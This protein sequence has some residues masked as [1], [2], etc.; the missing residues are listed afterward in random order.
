MMP[1]A[2]R[3]KA[4]T[5]GGA[6]DAW[7]PGLES[8]IPARL[9]PR[10][11]LF[12]PDNAFSG[13]AEA[14]EASE[15]CG[16]PAARMADLKV[17]RMAVHELLVR[18][19]ADLTVPDG[20]DYE[21]LG[22]SLR[23]MVRTIHEKHVVPA[24]PALEGEYAAIRE[25]ALARMKEVLGAGMSAPEGAG[26][27]LLSRLLGRGGPGGRPAQDV[28]EGPREEQDLALVRH[29]KERVRL[30]EDPF[31]A[32]IHAALAG[33][34]DALVGSRGRLDT[35]HDRMA[36]VAL[37]LFCQDHGPRLVRRMVAPIFDAAAEAEGF[38]RL[39][40]Q[41]R[42][43]V[44]NVKGASAAGKSTIRPKQR[45]LAAELGI[46]WEDF[47]LISPDY[48]RKYL[49]DYDGLG[50]DYKYAAMLTGEELAMIDQKLDRYMEEK[51]GRDELPHLL[52]DR[53][54]FDSFSVDSSGDYQSKLLT[55]FGNTVFLFFV[56]TPPAATVERAWARGLSTGRY[57]AVDDLLHHNR[58]AYAGMSDLFF[59]W[60]AIGDKTVHFEFLD[61]GVPEGEGPRTIAFGEGR[62]MVVLD[63]AALS[64]IDRFRDVDVDARRPED[65]LPE[66][67]TDHA[68]LGQCLARM[69][70]IRLADHATG[71]IWG[72][73]E[74]GE[75]RAATD[76]RD[77]PGGVGG[78]PAMLDALGW[79]DAGLP[80]PDPAGIDGL[81]GRHYT[82]GRWGRD[83]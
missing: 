36:G 82:L 3:A 81:D 54:R 53:F 10:I 30:E 73:I 43:I 71:R 74:N 78:D 9:A 34:G 14:S 1:K 31:D 48:W 51:A 83:A 7:N 40:F 23:G 12:H 39:P 77:F 50:D 57:K 27:S 68:F 6:F 11:S 8:T 22:L 67:G 62:D 59:S 20:P 66:G 35:D 80:A 61:N 19:T 5:G 79:K 52:I 41:E 15:Y 18:V 46:D 64:N 21:T 13:H 49:I 38:R 65:V 29:W 24:L 60:T 42:R 32:A 69:G 17:E 63:A 76:R 72:L 2:G 16:L 28:R 45:E 47:A 33:L 70:T 75:W 25:R 37:A 55:R 58:E 56:V 26:G 4:K 44:M